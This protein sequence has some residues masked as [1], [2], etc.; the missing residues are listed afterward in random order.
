VLYEVLS[1][2]V[3]SSETFT[4]PPLVD[5][6]RGEPVP[7]PL[8]ELVQGCLQMNPADRPQTALEVAQRVARAT[9]RGAASDTERLLVEA[10]IKAQPEGSRAPMVLGALLLLGGAGTT[11]WFV[12]RPTTPEVIV[13]PLPQPAPVEQHALAPVP[14][15][16]PPAPAPVAPVDPRPRVHTVERHGK[17]P[18]SSTV[19]TVVVQAPAGAGAE[20]AP[21]MR[22]L[23]KEYDGLVARYGVNQLTTLEREVVRQALE[24]YAGNNFDA[25]KASM[26]DAESALKA[27]HGRLDR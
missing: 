23:Q 25:L 5:T 27:A 18:P 2:R 22:S 3:L 24:D 17:K 11:A 12:T 20:Y 8:A 7:G 9:P 1:G 26:T 10:G 4:P 19:T 15:D 6:A 14:V 21:R 16:P 13:Q